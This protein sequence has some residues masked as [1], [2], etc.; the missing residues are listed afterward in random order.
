MDRTPALD[1][2]SKLMVLNDNSLRTIYQK[3]KELN[4]KKI[5]L[6]KIY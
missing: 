1:R 5:N 4:P 2:C 3:V 6:F